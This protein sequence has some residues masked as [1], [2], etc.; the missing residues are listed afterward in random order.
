MSHWNGLL[1]AHKEGTPITKEMICGNIEPET[2]QFPLLRFKR[3]NSYGLPQWN[4]YILISKNALEDEEIRSSS[5]SNHFYEYPVYLVTSGAKIIVL[6][7]RKKVLRET[8]RNALNRDI[9][10]NLRSIDV[11]IDDLICQCMQED[12][13]FRITSVNG[14]YSGSSKDIKSISLH[15]L[16]VTESSLFKAYHDHFNFFSCGVG[17]RRYDQIPK[18]HERK[19][20]EIVKLGNKGNLSAPISTRTQAIE[21]MKVIQFVIQNRFVDSWVPGV[22]F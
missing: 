12:S 11:H 22:S 5:K 10:P 4:Q 1:L 20:G 13:E 7:Q 16:N 8:V 19:P 17:R 2:H 9:F 21:F 14:K 18:L 6:A 3:E 15:G